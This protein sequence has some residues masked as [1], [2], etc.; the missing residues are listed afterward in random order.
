VFA[1]FSDRNSRLTSWLS[2]AAANEGPTHSAA[3]TRRPARPGAM[4]NC[5][6]I[7]LLHSPLL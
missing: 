6:E 4:R 5:V 1:N 2:E 3:K 7:M